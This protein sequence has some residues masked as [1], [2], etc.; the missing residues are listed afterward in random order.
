M[1]L[2]V[3][4][5][6]TTF[7]DASALSQHPLT[8]VERRRTL[9]LAEPCDFTSLGF[10]ELTCS[11]AHEMESN[12][13]GGL[14]SSMRG[15]WVTT[16]GDDT[17]FPAP[18]ED[19]SWVEWM[20]YGNPALA[21]Q[22][23]RNVGPAARQQ[24]P[25]FDSQHHHSQPQSIPAHSTPISAPMYSQPGDIPFTFGQS[26]DASPAFDFNGH[27]LSSPADADVQQQ[28]GFYSPPMWQQQQQ[29]PMTNHYFSPSRFDPSSIVSQPPPPAST[30]SLHHSPNSL[31]NGR[32]SSSS[33]HSSPEPAT[34]TKKRKTL[35]EDDDE[36]DT[37]PSG[38]KERGQPPKK[39]AHNMIEKRYRT[40]L[41]DKIAALRDSRSPL[42][43]V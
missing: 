29:Q 38:K 3:L 25:S 6:H 23:S 17:T 20:R 14:F 24:S 32:A 27:A 9:S 31:N 15:P 37:P 42:N 4:E 40:N 34:N 39:T 16:A 12:M 8:V 33:S 26:L 22:L 41:N 19:T 21:S 36:F 1:W 28:N 30:P 43:W 13:E 5:S 2:A 7:A 10:C 18:A 35:E 11:S